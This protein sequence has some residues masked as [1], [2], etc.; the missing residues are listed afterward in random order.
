MSVEQSSIGSERAAF[1][2]DEFCS[3]HRISRGMIY[4]LWQAGSGPRF[5]TVGARRL[6]SFEAASDWRRAREH[7]SATEAA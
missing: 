3:A 2:I 7:D 4:K 6:I 1:T 5:M